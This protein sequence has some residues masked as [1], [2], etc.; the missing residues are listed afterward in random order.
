MTE[1]L[2]IGNNNF[3][4]HPSGA[5]FW[6]EEKTLL[7]ADVHIGKTA[8]FRKH[9]IAVPTNVSLEN[10]TKLNRLIQFFKPEKI[11]FLG[12][13]FHST[14]N[15]EWHLFENW[16]LQQNAAITLVIGNHDIIAPTLF[17]KLGITI[18]AEI[19]TVEFLFTHHPETHA[20]LFNFCGHIHP[21]YKLRG[22]GKQLLKLPCF[23]K[24]G[25]QL[26]LPAFG[27]FTGN[28]YLTKSE[29]DAIYACT[30]EAIFHIKTHS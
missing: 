18:V 8:H 2:S 6:V 11:W 3:I 17:K 5:L 9:G 25:N 29:A 21:G 4:L 20:T 10:F 24:K 19:R 26:I 16:V 1:D 22:L 15:N 27:D 7:V 13:L 14:L 12:D 23:A 28:Y 30:E